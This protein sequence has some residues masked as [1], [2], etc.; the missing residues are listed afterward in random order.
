MNVATRAELDVITA[1]ILVLQLVD[2]GYK[3]EAAIQGL[4]QQQSPWTAADISKI[5]RFREALLDRL[6]LN[7]KAETRTSAKKLGLV[8]DFE[9]VVLDFE[10]VRTTEFAKAA[11]FYLEA[12]AERRRGVLQALNGLE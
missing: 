7:P 3:K 9:P 12:S 4:Q 6:S 11:G 8:T 1:I 5:V 10:D 2:I